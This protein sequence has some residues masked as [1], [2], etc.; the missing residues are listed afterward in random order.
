MAFPYS[1]GICICVLFYISINYV[2]TGRGILI[3]PDS[4]VI[5]YYKLLLYQYNSVSKLCRRNSRM[6][7]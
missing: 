4:F 1:N 5:R 7:L 3:Y 6:A 2:L